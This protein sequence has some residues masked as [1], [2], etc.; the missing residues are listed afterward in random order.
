MT[1]AVIPST[2]VTWSLPSRR[3]QVVAAGLGRLGHRGRG[4]PSFETVRRA[5]EVD[6]G[7]PEGRRQ[8]L[9]RVDLAGASRSRSPAKAHR[10]ASPEASMKTRRAHARRAPP[11]SRRRS[12]RP[13]RRGP[14]RPGAWRGAGSATPASVDQ[15]L[16]GDLEVLGEVGDAGPGAVG[17]RA[18]RGPGPSVAQ[19]RR[20]RRRRSRRRPCAPASPACRSRRTCRG[21]RCSCRRGT[22]AARS[23][24]TDAPP[25]AA[26][27][28]A[29]RAGGA[30]PDDAD[31]D[32]R[33]GPARRDRHGRRLRRSP[34]RPTS[35]RRPRATW[36]V[37]AR[38]SSDRK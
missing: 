13:G 38:D 2:G 16:P 3:G 35:R 7:H 6:V 31:V 9:G 25:R 17:V 1:V 11:A 30:G 37:T 32:R 29:R 18:A 34:R 15:P 5:R 19:R 27:I 14:R 28:A 36:P 10:S 21:R 12:T 33:R 26:A 8:G 24:R 23:S 20:R 22:A 4:T